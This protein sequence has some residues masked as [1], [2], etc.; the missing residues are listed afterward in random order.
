M[1]TAAVIP[2]QTITRIVENV[3]QAQAEIAQAFALLQTA[4]DRL[5][6]TMGD[7]GGYRHAYLWDKDV[8]EYNLELELQTIQAFQTRQ[9]WEY[10]IRQTGLEHFMTEKRCKALQ[11]Q[12]YKGDL[13][14][15]SVE[16]V[17]STL[18]GL[19]QQADGLFAES[20][21]EVWRWLRP[22]K[23]TQ[24]GQLKTNKHYC[25]PYKVIINCAVEN[26]FRGGFRINTHRRSLF[27]SL[28]NVLS[29]LDGLGVQQYPNDLV[30]QLN[31]TLAAIRAP[32]W[33]D[34]GPYMT[35]KPYLNGNLHV[36]FTKTGLIDELNRRA[37][38]ESLPEKD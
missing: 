14:S 32:Q 27:R 16:N 30:T 36:W 19:G 13:P 11:E 8:R 38:D 7:K 29:L 23:T 4:K 24:A 9:A 33:G 21:E 28:G 25:V 15:L 1:T 31:M 34:A 26:E 12:I 37:G 10:L 5:E 18:Q 2:R 22:N 6:A 3:T 17:L 35:V 20:L